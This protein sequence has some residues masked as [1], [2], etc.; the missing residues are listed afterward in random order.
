MYKFIDNIFKIT[1]SAISNERK[2]VFTFSEL[3]Y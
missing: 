2:T 3:V 1:T